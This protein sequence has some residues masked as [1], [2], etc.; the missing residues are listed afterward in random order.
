MDYLSYFECAPFHWVST[1][2]A[3]QQFY[4]HGMCNKCGGDGRE[5]IPLVIQSFI[6]MPNHTSHLWVYDDAILFL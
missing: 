2:K 1:L 4:M 5:S 3:D 6:E